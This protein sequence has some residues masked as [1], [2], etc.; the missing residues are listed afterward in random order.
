MSTIESLQNT[1]AK[2]ADP[3]RGASAAELGKEDFLRL[4]VSQLENQDPL[5]PSDPTEFTA[6]LAQYSSLEQLT[7]INKSMESINTLSE[8]FGR[9]SAL[10]LIDRSMVIN[11]NTFDFDGQNADMGFSFQDS[12]ESVTL[13]IRNENGQS[14]AQMKVNSPVSGENWVGWDGTD[15]NGRQAPSGK[16]TFSAI[17]VDAQGNEIHGQPLVESRITGADFSD[18]DYTLLTDSGPVEISDITRVK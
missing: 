6:Q 9:L 18:S 14:V 7:N 3:A 10:S 12:V 11:G 13:Y 5:N 1:G 16:Y 15:S 8:E 2:N 4:L 17:G